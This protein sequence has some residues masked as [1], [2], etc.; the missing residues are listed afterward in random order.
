MEKIWFGWQHDIF[1]KREGYLRKIP[2]QLHICSFEDAKKSLE[3]SK[4]Y[5]SDILLPPTKIIPSPSHNYV[6][7]QKEVQWILL[8]EAFEQDLHYEV[9]WELNSFI[10]QVLCALLK[11]WIRFDVVWILDWETPVEAKE[12]L[13]WSR[14]IKIIKHYLR[15]KNI[16]DSSNIIVSWNA[17]KFIDTVFIPQILSKKSFLQKLKIFYW[18]LVFRGYKNQIKSEQKKRT[19]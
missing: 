15:V 3:L 5:I 17:I 10:D 7:V 9:L 2:N 14:I 4:I 18:V 1:R 12:K 6:V 16:F 13:T 19:K 8:R 11:D